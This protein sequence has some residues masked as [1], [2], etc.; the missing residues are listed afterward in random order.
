MHKLIKKTICIIIWAYLFWITVYGI[1]P[2]Y[3]M[4]NLDALTI[5]FIWILWVINIGLY[6]FLSWFM[7]NWAWGKDKK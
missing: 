7:Y 6:I 1:P 2:D 5:T 4:D 3:L